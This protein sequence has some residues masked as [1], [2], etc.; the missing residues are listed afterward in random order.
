MHDVLT[1]SIRRAVASGEFA[2]AQTLWEDY[3]ERLNAELR[4]GPVSSAWLAEMEQLAEWCRTAT[5]AARSQAQDMLNALA[6]SRKYES[7]P[8]VGSTRISASL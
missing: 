8:A 1:S 2:K 3:T 6:A 7:Q 5:L 4:A